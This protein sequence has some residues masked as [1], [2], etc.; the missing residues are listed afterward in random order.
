MKH[1]LHKSICFFS[2]AGIG[3]EHNLHKRVITFLYYI[4]LNHWKEK[5]YLKKTLL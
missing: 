1:G 5:H 3:M 2:V 4:F